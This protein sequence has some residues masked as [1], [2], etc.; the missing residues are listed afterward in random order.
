MILKTEE[1][2]QVCKN[3]FEAVDTS[4]QQLVSETLELQVVDKELRLSV[5]NREYFVTVRIPLDDRVEEFT[6][7]VDARLFLQLISKV[8]T[9]EINLTIKDK[10]LVI[11]A[12]GTYK[13]PMIYDGDEMVKL[14]RIDLGETVTTKFNIGSDILGSILLYNT[15]ELTKNIVQSVVQKL[16]YLDQDGCITFTTGACVNSFKLASPVSILLDPKIVK[17]FKLFGENCE[18]S[19]TLSYSDNNGTVLPIVRFE[20]GNTTLTAILSPNTTLISKVPVAAIRGRANKEYP[21]STVL[22][23]QSVIDS[24][25]R[26]MLFSRKDLNNSV[27]KLKFTKDSVTFSDVAGENEE[28]LSYENVSLPNIEE[29]S[30]YIDLKDLKLTLDGYTDMYVNISFGDNAAVVITKENAKTSIK[31]VIPQIRI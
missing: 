9:K 5:T 27:A 12:N 17:L 30:C 8:T 29:Y 2:Q 19:F 11:K 7:V 28:V 1:L 16:Y 26:L 14:S 18:V 4:S 24:I 10:V 6:T 31:N 3:L 13:L 22:S 21:F 23:R 20:N 15:K 25:T